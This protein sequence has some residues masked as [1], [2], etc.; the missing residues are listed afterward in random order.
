MIVFF[1]L[2]IDA[3]KVG[4][5]FYNGLIYLKN[6][7][8]KNLQKLCGYCKSHKLIHQLGKTVGL[9]QFEIELE[10]KDFKEYNKVAEE[11]LNAFPEM[12]VRI[13]P[14]L[15]YK[16]YNPEYNFLNYISR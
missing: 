7:S 10:V 4:R 14:V 16:E 6:S 5:D 15:L 12:I 13:E 9:W 1:R 11:L 3:N 8:S 2:S